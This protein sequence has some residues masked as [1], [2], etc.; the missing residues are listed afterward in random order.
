MEVGST[1]CVT[2]GRVARHVPVACWVRL[3]RYVLR[4]VGSH[5][6][7]NGNKIK[8]QHDQG[9]LQAL[10]LHSMRNGNMIKARRAHAYDD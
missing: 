3:A 10:D 1:A 5:G 8:A 6:M 2:G 7:C 4:E 9:L